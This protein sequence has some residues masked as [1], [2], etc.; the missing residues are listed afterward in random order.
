MTPET[1]EWSRRVF[2]AERELDPSNANTLAAAREHFGRMKWKE[3]GAIEI[4][5]EAA[6]TGQVIPPKWEMGACQ[7]Y[8]A[9][10]W[11]KEAEGKA[12]PKPAAETRPDAP[13]P[14]PDSNADDLRL[15]RQE[16]VKAG[17]E[18]LGR[19]L[20]RLKQGSGTTSAPDV[21][22]WSKWV[23]EAERELDPSGAG[24]VKAAREH[25][26]RMKANEARVTQIAKVKQVKPLDLQQVAYQRVEAEIW[27]KEAEARAAAKP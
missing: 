6:K 20:E 23:F 13:K 16:K 7:R 26:E 21:Y 11:L 18:E 1:Y 8:E 10:I 14:Q 22:E 4:A 17:R 15:L 5:N 24:T 3:A 25:V 27:L 2:E 19:Q 12:A 9:E